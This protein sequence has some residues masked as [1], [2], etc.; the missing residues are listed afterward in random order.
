MRPN[1]RLSPEQTKAF[2]VF[3]ESLPSSD[4]LS[5]NKI[6][7]EHVFLTNSR[8]FVYGK[9][10]RKS[11][12]RDVHWVWNQSKSQKTIKLNGSDV[13]LYKLNPRKNSKDP[14]LR[15]P[16]YKLWVFTI[17]APSGDV[18]DNINFLWCEKGRTSMS[19]PEPLV[20]VQTPIGRIH[21]EEISLNQLVFLKEFM[22]PASAQYF[23]GIGN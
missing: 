5:V 16:A 7:P 11:L 19:A 6:L 21:P 23:F 8:I 3:K 1:T 9:I 18:A 14:N 15:Y 17:K 20:P 13:T 12:P 10:G 22:E 2:D 4:Q